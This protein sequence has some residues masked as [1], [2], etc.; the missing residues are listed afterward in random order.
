MPGPL[1]GNT[2]GKCDGTELGK[3]EGT[4]LGKRGGAKRDGIPTGAQVTPGADGSAER[5]KQLS[6]II[7]QANEEPSAKEGKAAQECMNH[8][9]KRCG[10]GMAQNN[11]V[12]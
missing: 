6:D 8:E 4:I 7:G 3:S 2:L 10:H 12:L 5:R 1:E 9:G 11:K